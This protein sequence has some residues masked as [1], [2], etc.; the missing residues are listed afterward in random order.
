MHTVPEKMAEQV[1]KLTRAIA[2]I[3][4]SVAQKRKVLDDAIK[5]RKQVLA[6]EMEVGTAVTVSAE[7]ETVFV[8]HIP[9]KPRVHITPERVS[10]ALRAL[11]PGA[12]DAAEE[13]VKLCTEPPGEPRI[14]VGK[15][16]PR[17]AAET[18]HA[19]RDVAEALVA[20]I[21]AKRKLGEATA[22]RKATLAQERDAAQEEVLAGME[23]AEF[24]RM[25][26]AHDG[27]TWEYALSRRD[28]TR[29]KPLGTRKAKEAIRASIAAAGS[30]ARVRADDVAK[31]FAEMQ[32]AHKEAKLVVTC[33]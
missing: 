27:K 2:E 9:G 18:L 17:G 22:E 16:L 7:G 30:A 28:V 26:V 24:Q 15:R 13:V 3:E 20:E 19:P 29:T 32:P 10:L 8:A 21:A 6:R 14:A 33:M 4:R 23:F 11:P 25:T 5:C 12:G 1:C 31:R